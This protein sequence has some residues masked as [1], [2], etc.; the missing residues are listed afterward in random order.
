[1][2]FGWL[3]PSASPID[4]VRKISRSLNVIGARSVRRMVSAKAMSFVGSR[5][6]NRIMAN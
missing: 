4:A 3:S 6:D 5:S 2:R 1:V